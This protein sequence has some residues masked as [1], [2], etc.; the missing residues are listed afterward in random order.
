LNIKTGSAQLD[1]ALG[2]SI[3]AILNA[4]INHF[5]QE[6]LSG[7]TSAAQSIPNIPDNW[8]YNGQSLSS[9]T[10]SASQMVVPNNVTIGTT[11]PSNVTSTPIS[12]GTPPYSIQGTCTDG[13]TVSQTT[14]T[15]CATLGMCTTSGSSSETTQANCPSG[16]NWSQTAKWAPS[17]TSPDSRVAT[18]NISGSTL[19]VTGV[20]GGQTSFI[21]Q[22][23]SSSPQ[24]ATVQV[25]TSLILDFNNPPATPNQ[26][27]F[28]TSVGSSTN[29]TLSGGTAPYN[30]QIEPDSSIALGLISANTLTIIGVAPG[31]TTIELQ[32][33]AGTTINLSIVIGTDT[34][35]V[36]SPAASVS[37]VNDAITGT[38]TATVTISGGTPPYSIVKE[39]DPS[40]ILGSALISGSTLNVITS[41][42]GSASITIQDSFSPT[43][44]TLNISITAGSGPPA[45][46]NFDAPVTQSV[47]IGVN[48]SKS[49]T[50]SGGSG[51]GTYSIES[52]SNPSVGSVSISK[53]N[54][55][56]ITGITAGSDTVVIQD[57]SS[58]ATSSGPAASGAQNKTVTINITVG[59]GN[60]NNPSE[61]GTCNFTISGRQI[62]A[63]MPQSNCVNSPLYGTWTAD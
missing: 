62:T 57:S 61:S 26:T 16:S 10:P 60:T 2:N 43:P 1:A 25:T 47:S 12:G 53:S 28:A 33:S 23:S 30:I 6:G 5:L 8:T 34:Q 27:S 20:G 17:T 21:V 32:D 24:T 9:N 29:I 31:S 13:T 40:S 22:D 44:G 45:D 52:Q 39:S 56:T 51:P 11:P 63:T 15:V 7:L 19:T 42:N 49:L 35:L 48:S 38:S 58:E 46:I 14:Q 18:A 36:A 3:S 37:T 4:F 55:I 59:T 54:T 41:A 50:M